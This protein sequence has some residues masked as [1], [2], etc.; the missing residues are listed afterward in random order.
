MRTTVDLSPD[1]LNRIRKVADDEGVSFKEA[2]SRVVTRGLT[3]TPPAT[4]KPYVLPKYN[5]GIDQVVDLR[6]INTI[7]AEEDSAEFARKFYPNQAGA[8]EAD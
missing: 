8:L 7:M 2:L 6:R 3:S 4:R 5:L 1:L